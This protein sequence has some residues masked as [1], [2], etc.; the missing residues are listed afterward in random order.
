MGIYSTKYLLEEDLSSVQ[1]PNNPGVDLDQIEKDIVGDDGNEAH[2]EEIDAAVDGVIDDPLDECYQIM[3][4]SEYN[5]N[6]LLQ[7]IGLQE[8]RESA[9]GKEYIMEAGALSNFFSRVKDIFV[10]MFKKITEFFKK[11]FNAIKSRVVSDKKFIATYEKDIRDGAE[12]LKSNGK[13]KDKQGYSFDNLKKPSMLVGVYGYISTAT[14]E[15]AGEFDIHKYT[16]ESK[17]NEINKL[18][19]S[20]LKNNNVNKSASSI[21]ELNKLLA[22]H[23]YGNK[24]NVFNGNLTADGIISVLKDGSDTSEIQKQYNNLKKEYSD[25]LK[26]LKDMEKSATKEAKSNT[27]TVCNFYINIL[28]QESNINN[29]VFTSYTKAVK[30]R[31]NQ[32]RKLANSFRAASGNA[33]SDDNTDNTGTKQESTGI[34]GNIN[35]I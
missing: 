22:E 17:S 13:L 10:S 30:A 5:Y 18:F 9:S 7:T 1:D 11:V 32:A 24:I 21:S 31:R 12:V 14:R 3:Y 27:T 28:R 25:V 4:E 34:F 20:A 26:G 35:F 19:S 8:L 6:M 33:K 23:Y 2:S 16:E 29:A 15:L